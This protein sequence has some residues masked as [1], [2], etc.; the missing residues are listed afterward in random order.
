LSRLHT[1]LV[2]EVEVLELLELEELRVTV[3]EIDDEDEE[4]DE[5]LVAEGVDVD[6]LEAGL[7]EVVVALEELLDVESEV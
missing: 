2:V 6:E 7:A 4:L 5:E 1:S 3:V